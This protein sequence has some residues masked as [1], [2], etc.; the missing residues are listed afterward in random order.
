MNTFPYVAGE[1]YV[2][3]TCEQCKNRDPIFHDL[4]NGQ[5]NINAIY[6]WQCSKCGHEGIYEG[7]AIELYQHPSSAAARNGN[8]AT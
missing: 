3:I 8:G 4:T 7:S 1:W 5:A 2:V 6:T